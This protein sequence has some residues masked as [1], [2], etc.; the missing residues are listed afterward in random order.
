LL[1]TNATPATASKSPPNVFQLNFSLSSSHPNSAINICV[2]AT[3]HAVVV[4]S[5]VNN[6]VD[7]SH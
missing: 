5:A 1:I 3:I 2:A 4:A 7:C 6:P